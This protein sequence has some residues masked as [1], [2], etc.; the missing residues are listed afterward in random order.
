MVRTKESEG[1][2][3]SLAGPNPCTPRACETP[4][5]SFRSRP[6]PS[7]GDVFYDQVATP[8]AV[9]YSGSRCH[10]I[11][12]HPLLRRSRSGFGLLL[13]RKS[14]ENRYSGVRSNLDQ[15]VGCEG[16]PGCSSAWERKRGVV[17]QLAALPQV[18]GWKR[19]R[20]YRGGID[21]EGNVEWKWRGKGKVRRW[22]REQRKRRR[23]GKYSVSPCDQVDLDQGSKRECRDRH[24]G[25]RRIGSLEPPSIDRIHRLK[26]THVGKEH[27]DLHHILHR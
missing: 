23:Q 27:A 12:V 17:D 4:T 10:R 20:K 13:L 5:Q 3:G 19:I 7:A 11:R 14:T 2:S 18:W 8:L 1:P 22:K 21:N 6:S 25:A 15:A 16:S 9:V 26:V 24:G